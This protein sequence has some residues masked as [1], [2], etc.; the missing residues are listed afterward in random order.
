MTFQQ[1]VEK[2]NPYTP[3]LAYST[4]QFDATIIIEQQVHLTVRIR[5]G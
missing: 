5:I 1:V 3:N 2:A 4:M